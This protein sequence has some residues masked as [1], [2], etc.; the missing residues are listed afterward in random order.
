MFWD[1]SW[2]HNNCEWKVICE[3]YV[4]W[5]L[6]LHRS[7]H[8][9]NILHLS[10]IILVSDMEKSV[11]MDRCRGSA[12]YLFV[13]FCVSLLLLFQGLFPPSPS[14]GQA[15]SPHLQ[16][17]IKASSPPQ[18][19]FLC[20]VLVLS[21]LPLRHYRGTEVKSGNVSTNE[22]AAKMFWPMRAQGGE[23]RPIGETLES[24]VVFNC[25]G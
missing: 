19:K 5:D 8:N 25:L 10:C 20:F 7:K 6:S 24:V 13:P 1:L 17:W 15:S 16:I 9:W 2:V 21:R 4:F 12:Y 14:H 11:C 22:S 23:R 3:W 18:S